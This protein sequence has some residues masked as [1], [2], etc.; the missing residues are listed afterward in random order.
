M[1]PRGSVTNEMVEEWLDFFSISI[2]SLD[3]EATVT[4]R[5]FIF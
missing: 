1:V 2:S 3:L 5:T 4:N